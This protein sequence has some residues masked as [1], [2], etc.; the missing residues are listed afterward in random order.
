M[1][2]AFERELV[3]KSEDPNVRK[4]MLECHLREAVEREW[5]VMEAC[6]ERSRQVRALNEYCK[7][8][9]V[10]G[11]DESTLRQRLAD[12]AKATDPHSIKISRFRSGNKRGVG[13]SRR[14]NPVRFSS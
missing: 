10:G 8:Q 11:V 6:A 13:F 2:G 4:Y 12:H 3:E 7:N 1:I 14:L 9:L 5:R